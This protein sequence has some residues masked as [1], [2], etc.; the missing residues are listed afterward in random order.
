MSFE[1]LL[2]HRCDLYDQMSVDND[3]SPVTKYVKVNDRP[4]PC[5]LDLSLVRAGKDSQWMPAAGKPTDRTG[6]LFLKTDAPIKSGMRIAMRKGPQ[7]TF[8]IQGALDEIYGFVESHHLEVGVSE[9][10]SLH[11]RGTKTEIMGE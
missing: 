11:W 7:G 2:A 9:V 6:I 8:Q 5:R 1:S 10:P 4:V 3:G